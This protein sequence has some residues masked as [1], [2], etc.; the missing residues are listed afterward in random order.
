MTPSN[1]TTLKYELN[2]SPFRARKKYFEEGNKA[3]TLLVRYI[4]PREAQNTIAAIRTEGGV[5]TRDPT[6]VNMTFRAFYAT[7][8][9]SETQAEQQEIQHMFF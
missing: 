8:Y 7:L 5:L 9:L 3:G 2:F 6:E 1:L 4:K